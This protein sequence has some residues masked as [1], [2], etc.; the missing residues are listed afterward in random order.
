LK[1]TLKRPT[2][3]HGKAPFPGRKL[4]ARLS[5]GH[6]NRTSR[7]LTA[8]QA[9]HSRGGANLPGTDTSRSALRGGKDA[10]RN[11]AHLLDGMVRNLLICHKRKGELQLYRFMLM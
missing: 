6:P 9:Q 3:Y 5:I 10:R 1:H 11:A 8:P 4:L 7:H 2:L